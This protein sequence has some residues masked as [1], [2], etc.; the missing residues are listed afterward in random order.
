[1]SQPVQV[2]HHEFENLAQ[3]KG[4]L[5][6]PNRIGDIFSPWGTA[7]EFSVVP[8]EDA[9]ECVVIYRHYRRGLFSDHQERQLFKPLKFVSAK[10]DEES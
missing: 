4:L 5:S 10:T 6:I 9:N 3:E 1:M 2:F 7:E 8:P